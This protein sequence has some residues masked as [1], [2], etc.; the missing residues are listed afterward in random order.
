[1]GG[2]FSTLWASMERFWFEAQIAAMR[3]RGGIFRQQTTSE[4]SKIAMGGRGVGGI[5]N[6]V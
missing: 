3:Y 5:R 2:N 4:Y 1:V 6:C